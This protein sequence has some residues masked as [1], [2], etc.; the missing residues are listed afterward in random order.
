MP[1]L[2]SI[3]MAIAALLT[4]T[5][6]VVG[7]AGAQTHIENV[8]TLRYTT[9]AGARV[10]QSNAVAV[11][12]V[13]RR[14]PTKI[15][16]RRLPGGYQLDYSAFECL[17]GNPASFTPN[18]VNAEELAKAAPLK[19]LNIENPMVV[20]LENPGGNHDPNVREDSWLTGDSG[21][22]QAKILLTETGPNTG[23]FAGAFPPSSLHSGG[24]APPCD[25]T[26][27]NNGYVRL[28]FAEDPFS[29]ASEASLLIDPLGHVFDSVTGHP[30]NGA[31]VTLIDDATGLPATQVFGDDGISA[32]PNTVVTG[33]VVTDSSGWIY[34]MEDGDFRFPLAAPGRYRLKV[35]PP[36]GYSSPSKATPEALAGLLDPH[37]D[38]YV[39]S[40]A[41]YEGVFVLDSPDPVRVDLPIDPDIKAQALLPNALTVEKSASVREAEPGDFVQFRIIVSNPNK[42]AVAGITV[43]DQLP[44]GMRYRVGSARGLTEPTVSRDGRSLQFSLANIGSE[45]TAQFSYVVE[46]TPGAPQGEA[47]NSALASSLTTPTGEPGEA[48]V[49]IRPLLFSD[50]FT[51]I[52]RVTEGDCGD[53]LSGRKGVP[54]V[55]LVL[56]D[57]TLVVTDREGLYHFEGVRPG[58]HVVQLDKASIPGTHEAVAC[59]TDTRQAG[60]PLSRFVEATGGSLQ[61]VDFQLRRNGKTVAA[62]ETLPITV[63]DDATAAGNRDDWLTNEA[64]GID[65]LFPRMEHNP[66]APA[67]RVVIKHH[68][69]QR[70]A[71]RV[72]GEL[73]D[74]MT[75][76]GTDADKARDVAVS[77]WTGVPINERDN[78]LEA[79]VLNADGSV[80]TTLQRTVHYANAP[81]RATYIPEKSRLVADGLTRPLIAVRLTDRDGKPVRAGTITPFSVDAPYAAAM[82]A[83]LQT[84]RQL[85]GRERASATAI[86]VGDDGLAFLALEP[87][88]QAGAAHIVVTLEDQGMKQISEFRP[89]L[90]A[91]AKDWIVVGFGKGTIGYDML[92]SKSTALPKGERNNV[93]TDGQLSFYA[94]GRVKG[95]WLLTIAYDSD[96]KYDP[97]RGLL[98][99]IDPDRYYTVYGDGTR[100]TYDA[101]TRRKLY[102]RLE[103]KE[104]Y[105]LF[106]DFETGLV[107]SRLAR[108]SRTMN[109]VKAEYQG[110]HILFSG[111]AANTDQ[112]YGRDEIQGNGL[113]G[114]YRLSSGSIVPNTDKIRLETRDRF[115]PE[116]IVDTQ[117][118][119][120]HIDYDI[121]AANGT[122]R[123]REPILGRDAD[124]NPI[125]IVADYEIYGGRARKFAGGGRVATRLA[126]GKVEMGASFLRDETAD[127]ATVG[128]VDVKA[129]VTAT[130]LVRA[131]AATGGKEGI[132]EG[133]AYLA[134]VEHHSGKVDGT[135]YVRQQDVNFGLGQQNFGE[136][137]TRKVGVDGRARLTDRLSITGAAWYQQNL[138][139]AG[140]RTAGEARVEYR[141]DT[142][143]V[144]AGAKFASDTG[145][146]SESNKSK[147]LSLGG[148]QRFFQQKL[149]LTG[150]TQFALGGQ[151]DSVDF[152]VRHTVGASW[153]FNNNIRLLA[154][155]EIA[156]GSEFKAHGTR[157]GFDI[158]PWAGAKL[159]S[160]INQ[161]K[162]DENGPRTFA[163]YGL[164][165]SLPIGKRW[166]VDATYDAATTVKGE[167]PA[168]DVINPL[169]PVGSGSSLGQSSTANSAVQLNGD[170]QAVTLGATYRGDL[171]SWNGRVEYRTGTDNDRWGITSNALRTLGQGKTIAAGVRVYT[172][173]DKERGNA[174]ASFASADIALAIRPLDSRW[175]LL[176]RFELR[177][178]RA[179]T[180]VTDRNVLGIGASVSGTVGQETTR[181]INNVAVNY[182]TGQE[183]AGHGFEASL[184]YGAK[185]VVGRFDDDKYTG[186]IDVIGAEIRKDIGTH[187]DVGVNGS[188][189]HAWN[190][191]TMAFAF[192]PSVGFSPGNNVWVSAGY[193]VSGYR[194][195][196]FEESRYTRQGPYVTMRMKFDQLSLGSVGRAMGGALR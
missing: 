178:E 161:E 141:R 55:R 143:I 145:I 88:T 126:K 169:H 163:Q 71:L 82:D 91:S 176:E 67:L 125:F 50:A 36:P 9:P 44:L 83:E 35:T 53:P 43:S 123:F 116:K 8:A 19:S 95:S 174:V 154:E 193:N 187:F 33:S 120:R 84:A 157:V 60:N 108:Y 119:T 142:G 164:N 29:D 117:Q 105:A 152:P 139:D 156:D 177:H 18:K 47:V 180:G 167:I 75:F 104:F 24:E 31:T 132:S 112:R 149:E 61:R 113:S 184:Y 52:G 166:T 14:Y 54:G 165:Q 7:V 26:R 58:T 196:D 62:T 181:A 189:Q 41:S 137:G 135:A 94:K 6:L 99:T 98:G 73:V 111:F 25:I 56:E 70:V 39:I 42:S 65:W 131:E 4:L 124:L 89:W 28:Y 22:R 63:E 13:R 87:T 40:T 109:G 38:H 16:F 175:S 15:S 115:R 151:K 158:K 10:I 179:D 134:E 1:S 32:Y 122:L 27:D 140:E 162:I 138:N 103:R 173:K 20:V 107:D 188:M 171:W 153:R 45:A 136:A 185:Y 160:T 101:A 64:P 85:A 2:R 37:G 130:T 144:F 148:S 77:I 170:Y 49:R 194:D 128:G 30:I 11:D 195:R 150:E 146:S 5:T 168:G 133:R 78:T 12:T 59:D 118:L 192:G 74:P 93:V 90:A 100:Q 186:F 172:V 57:G 102:L 34:R 66:R 155:H 80:A 68:A 21:V 86:V 147:L 191:K 72:N 76:D 79:Q 110:K 69:D 129:Q 96:K 182:R 92:K 127:T 183:G 51:L 46:I 3:L 97:E 48:A 121:D 114:P 23:V 81:V 159:M 17:G 190:A 106:G